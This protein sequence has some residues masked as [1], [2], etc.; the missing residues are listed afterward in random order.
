MDVTLRFFEKSERGRLEHQLH[1]IPRR[2][3]HVA[4]HVD[5]DLCNSHM[6]VALLSFQSKSCVTS[7][8]HVRIMYRCWFVGKSPIQLM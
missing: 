6:E 1:D 4:G 8:V 5:L 3:C 2:R 7:R